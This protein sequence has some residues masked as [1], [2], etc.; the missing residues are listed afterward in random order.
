MTTGDVDYEREYDNRGRVPEHPA[1]IEG[2][3]AAAAA[4]RREL[5]GELDRAYGAH[6]RERY[7]LF[8]PAEP[9]D[10]A[11]VLFIHGGYWQALEKA[12]FSHLAKGP[13]AHGL[14]VAVLGYPLCPEVPLARIVDA[15]GA[16]VPTVAGAADRRVVVCGHSAGGHL[17]AAVAA[18]AGDQRE[19]VAAGL[20][21]SGLFDLEPLVP[22]SINDALGLHVETARALSPVRW[23]GPAQRRFECWVG[24][25]ESAE[26][27]RQSRDLVRIWGEQGVDTEYEVVPAT[28]HFTVVGA[29]AD[30]ASPLSRRLADL[31]LGAA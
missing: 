28:N 26:Y 12:A 11:A 30:P 21:V 20:A 8:R 14:P 31:A 2:W 1:I 3:Y 17:A 25:E 13:L 5:D 10:G 23:A 18:T 9:R 16:A 15:V 7:D 19:L 22:T 4:A 24:G 27:H 29:L 6:P